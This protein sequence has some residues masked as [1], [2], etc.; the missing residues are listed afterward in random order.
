ME[1][2]T[3]KPVVKAG[4]KIGVDAKLGPNY[5]E[6]KPLRESLEEILQST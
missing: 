3:L 4:V 6:L 2:C 1:D 5:G